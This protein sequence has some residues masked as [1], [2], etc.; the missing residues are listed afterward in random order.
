MAPQATTPPYRLTLPTCRPHSEV[1][2]RHADRQTLTHT[3]QMDGGRGG[4]KWVVCVRLAHF[5]LKAARYKAG[6]DFCCIHQGRGR[7]QSSS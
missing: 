7:R 5:P 6:A 1:A 3:E 4:E 2:R